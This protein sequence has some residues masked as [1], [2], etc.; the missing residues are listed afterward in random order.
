MGQNTEDS[1][2]GFTCSAP[3]VAVAT[4]LAVPTKSTTKS[5]AT[6]NMH[7]PAHNIN[8]SIGTTATKQAKYG[9]L[10][11][12]N[13]A[14]VS[15][16]T[17]AIA[18]CHGPLHSNVHTHRPI[19]VGYAFGPKK[20][21]TMSVVMAE[22]SMAV[23]TVVT[24]FSD[25]H[26][27]GFGSGNGNV[28]TN[29]K[30]NSNAN[31]I[32][33]SNASAC[34]NNNNSN[35][36]S[37]CR[38]R[39]YKNMTVMPIST[40]PLPILPSAP[41]S[42]SLVSSTAT[43]QHEN[44][45]HLHI[46]SS[47]DSSNSHS[48]P[49]VEPSF[50]QS[51]HTHSFAH[52]NNDALSYASRNEY[53]AES[54][55]MP[56]SMEECPNAHGTSHSA[57]VN[58]CASK[59]SNVH[60]NANF[61]VNVNS[62][63]NGNGNGS[64]NPVPIPKITCIFPTP[65]FL[66]SKSSAVS[67]TS[68]E[69]ASLV[70]TTTI[71][72]TNASA[73]ASSH[74]DLHHLPARVPQHLQPMRVC[75]VPLDLDS[76]LDEQ[77]GGK[78]DAILH[79]MTEDILCKSQLEMGSTCRCNGNLHSDCVRDP[80]SNT[81]ALEESERQALRRIE[82]LRKYKQDH[83]ACCLVDHPNNVQALMNRADIANILKECLKGV[84]TKSGIPART[85]RYQVLNEGGSHTSKIE[86]NSNDTSSSFSSSNLRYR[87]PLIV[88]P[89]TAAGTKESHKM[90][91]LLGRHGLDKVRNSNKSGPSLL[92]EYSNHDGMLFK[93]YVLGKKVW[94]F[95]RPSL[96]NLPIGEI[97][98]EEGRGFV[99]FDSQRPYPSLIDFG[100]A[101]DS[102]SSSEMDMG[103]CNPGSAFKMDHGVTVAEI[104]PI[105]DSIRK[106]FGLELFGF[107]ILV[108]RKEETNRKEM[109][110]VDVNYFP[111]YKEVTN[112]PKMLAQYLAQCGIEGRLRSFEAS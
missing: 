53:D 3:S 93:V 74:T 24:H 46:T 82:R 112:F 68:L 58:T 49:D 30:A 16:S 5:T 31:G 101:L 95:K 36:S 71:S 109:L 18:N 98:E 55:S 107:D 57:V 90:G 62:N 97:G 63:S 64:N 40:S 102:N 81:P 15:T 39:K 8:T 7:I 100:I 73:S 75:F 25:S 65:F 52:W 91:I 79:K 111:S 105:A 106:A 27:Y 87:Y 103:G 45:A 19:L 83:P 61:H 96:P 104:R 32:N 77:H 56:P 9:A 60:K 89:L 4:S 47:C 28:S 84:T 29:A 70:T 43:G 59:M 108:A 110:V 44:H 48:E 2:Q 12:N 34:P 86:G 6:T 50:L 92:Q 51:Q 78:F 69:E 88:K 67:I 26:G 37:N 42:S 10:P 21:S 99:E 85:P 33:H 38:K 1:V 66:P 17:S 23:S 54:E 20:M 94:V 22:A 76:P 41:S 11:A 14:S 72:T 13:S 80:T 35:T